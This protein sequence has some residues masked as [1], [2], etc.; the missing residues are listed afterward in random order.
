MPVW[1][2]LLKRD[3]PGQSEIYY[4]YN[5]RFLQP[6]RQFSKHNSLALI[7]QLPVYV[8]ITPFVAKPAWNPAKRPFLC[9][10]H[11]KKKKHLMDDS[12]WN[13]TSP[14]WKI[15]LMQ[16]RSP[17]DLLLWPCLQATI[18]KKSPQSKGLSVPKVC[19]MKKK[20][21]KGAQGETTWHQN[22]PYPRL[23]DSVK[24]DGLTGEASAKLL[25]I[26]N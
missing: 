9:R 22:T 13:H 2:N 1:A 5:C 3:M 11:Q 6:Q 17:H 10:L 12:M 21:K 16:F 15:A 19:E 26:L 14:Y 23:L 18:S 7:F 4:K 25:K 20:K 8:F 24:R